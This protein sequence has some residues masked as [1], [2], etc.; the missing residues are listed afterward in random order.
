MPVPQVRGIGWQHAAV[1]WVPCDSPMSPTNTDLSTRTSDNIRHP[2]VKSVQLTEGCKGGK[3]RL[4][5]E[6]RERRKSEYFIYIL[7]N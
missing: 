7:S 3:K 6:G 1:K 2:D 5:A 4:D